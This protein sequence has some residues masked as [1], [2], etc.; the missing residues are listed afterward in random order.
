MN[1]D[2]L[3]RFIFEHYPVRGEIVRL[4]DSFKTIMEQ[5]AYPNII[6]KLLGETLAA[7]TLI[8]ATIK[9]KGQL[10]L[11]FQ[12]S[13]PIKMLVAKCNDK[14][15]IRG[16]AQWQQ[17]VLPDEIEKAF[18]MGNLVITLDRDDVVQ[19][20]QSI[21]PLQHRR[22]TEAIEYFFMQSEQLATRLW[23]IVGDHEAAGLLL[24]TLP[25]DKPED[26]EHF[27]R[28][29]ARVDA[30]FSETI[31]HQ[32]N[33]DVLKNIFA[34][35][36][37]RVFEVKPVTFRC[38]CTTARMENA[39]RTL[40]EAEAMHILKKKREIVVTCEYCNNHYAFDREYVERIFRDK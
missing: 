30:A 9:F 13:G 12:S 36:D 4:N 2:S 20:Y 34:E 3:Q 23:V 10:T 21:V 28:F 19:P 8:T 6:Q 16:L 24:Q 5:H 25:S 1:P 33:N 14:S 17:K 29:A 27:W 32:D 26:K 31:F 11:Q 15:E 18:G 22:V 37:V 7:A 39:I 38:N 40:G 35:E